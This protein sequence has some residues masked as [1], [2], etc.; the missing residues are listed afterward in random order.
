MNI[1]NKNKPS[2]EINLYSLKNS[3]KDLVVKSYNR[4]YYGKQFYK[5]NENENKNVIIDIDIMILLYRDY[6]DGILSYDEVRNFIK[7]I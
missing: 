7:E 3:I 1:Q 5:F 4:K 6:K 2:C